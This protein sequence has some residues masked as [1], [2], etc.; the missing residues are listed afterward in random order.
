MK[1]TLKINIALAIFA[2][3]APGFAS[4]SGMISQQI[5]IKDAMRGQTIE[6]LLSVVN[7][8]DSEITFKLSA[9]VDIANWVSLKKYGDIEGLINEITAP[10]KD[11]AKARVFIKVP[12]DTPNGE[13]SGH[14]IAF[15]SATPN[16][17]QKDNMSVGISQKFN[18]PVRITVTDIET[19]D[20][21][22]KVM[23][24]KYFI[25]KIE[26]LKINLAYTNE[27]NV[28]IRPHAQIKIFNP[29]N[30]EIFNAIYPYPE[31]EA[32][33]RPRA[34]KVIT[35]VHHFGELQEGRYR[36]EAIITL[37]GEE[38]YR[39]NFNF[40]VGDVKGAVKGDNANITNIF[41]ELLYS[42]T[43]INKT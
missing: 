17:E 10:P 16:P 42:L 35:V 34:T 28:S 12:D 21:K 11:W 18:R 22:T 20:F 39:D 36:V 38:K 7:S 26:P 9:E 4:A 29:N 27:G 8:G 6:E 5:E 23:P 19:V 31:N 43:T 33:V 41:L 3:M 2:M 30:E 1:N 32:P 13:Y 24:E 37:N 15:I 40:I 14:L 25:N